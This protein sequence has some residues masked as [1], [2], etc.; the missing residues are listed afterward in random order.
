MN[1]YDNA[2]QAYLGTLKDVLYNPE[3][4]S[5]PRG[6]PV[7][8]KFNYQFTIKN[9]VVKPIQTKDIVRNAVI[10][11]YSRKEFQAYEAATGLASTFTKISKF[12]DSIKNPDGTINSDYGH[13]IFKNKSCGS[14]FEKELQESKILKG[15]SEYIPVRRTPW[16]WA[17][18][19]LMNDQDTRQ[20]I[21]RFSLPEHQW[22]GNRD[23]TCTLHGF[24]QIRDNKLDL[25]ITMRSNDLMLGLVYDL[26]WFVS[27]MYRMQ[28]DLSNVY[29]DLKIGRYTH[30]VH[31]IHIYDRDIEKVK[32][33]LGI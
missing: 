7:L 6:L 12:W 17:L 31:N 16:E 11:T 33:M 25:T 8:E 21:I 22:K 27:L 20:A 13:L 24:F 9:P 3:S 2:D 26:P 4:M 5:S 1:I 23:Q 15:I 32:K 30:F 10:E 18:L 19:C 29:P 14:D 28:K